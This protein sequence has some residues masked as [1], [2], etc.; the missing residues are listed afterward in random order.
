MRIEII[1]ILVCATMPVYM[2]SS[3][4]DI[5]MYMSQRDDFLCIIYGLC[6]IFTFIETFLLL[7]NEG[8]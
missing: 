3:R 2:Q 7:A 4:R 1:M 5:K 8:L 6:Y